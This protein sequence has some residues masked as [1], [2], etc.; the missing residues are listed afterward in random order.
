M[1]IAENSESTIKGMGE[2]G[3]VLDRLFK[4]CVCVCVFMRVWQACHGA[5][6]CLSWEGRKGIG[7]T[8]FLV[9]VH[10]NAEMAQML[11]F[12]LSPLP[13]PCYVAI[14][15]RGPWNITA[16]SKVISFYC[17]YDNKLLT[18][19]WGH[20]ELPPKPRAWVCM[21]VYEGMHVCVC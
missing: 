18:V 6:V 5:C 20:R 10:R 13:P 3:R 2:V 17:C 16:D 21:C 14:A 7:V 12:S 1:T 8:L 19:G 9:G 11:S 15:A 4:V